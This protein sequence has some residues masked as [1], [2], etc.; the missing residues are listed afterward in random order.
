MESV[1]RHIIRSNQL[2][3][4]ILVITAILSGCSGS[5]ESV[6]SNGL[7]E[8]DEDVAMDGNSNP[9]ATGSDNASV[10]NSDADADE[11][12]RHIRQIQGLRT[13]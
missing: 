13:H 4:L 6:L 12:I 7:S 10:E 8:F 5:G 2:A 9:E 1:R 3:A 11:A